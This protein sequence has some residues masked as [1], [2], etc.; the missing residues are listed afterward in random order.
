LDWVGN[1]HHVDRYVRDFSY[2]PV[3]LV[4][5]IACQ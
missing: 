3:G 1:D 5:R 4:C 2:I